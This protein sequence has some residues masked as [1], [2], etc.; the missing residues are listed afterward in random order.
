MIKKIAQTACGI[1]NVG[2]DSRGFIHIGVADR[3]EHADK[4]KEIDNIEPIPVNSHWVV[5]VDREANKKGKTLEQYM[6]LFI[7]ALQKT[8]LSEHLKSSILNHI[9]IINYM[10]LSVIR[11]SIMAQTQPSFV[12]EECFIREASHTQKATMP[13]LAEVINRLKP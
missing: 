4:I 8:E 9:D 10:G 12:G 1:A 6:D 7:S 13:M 2:P 5:G 11:I 3:K